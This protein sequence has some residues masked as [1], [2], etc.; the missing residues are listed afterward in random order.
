MMPPPQSV[1]RLRIHASSST[2]RLSHTKLKLNKKIE[3][4][5]N[6]TTTSKMAPNRKSIADFVPTLPNN[7]NLKVQTKFLPLTH[8]AIEEE[9]EHLRRIDQATKSQRSEESS[10]ANNYWNWQADIIDS[11]ENKEREGTTGVFS[12]SSIEANLIKD[13]NGTSSS[14]ETESSSRQVASHDEYW[15]EADQPQIMEE[16]EPAMK[17]PQHVDDDVTSSYYWDWTFDQETESYWQWETAK[18]APHVAD[19][20]SHL[21]T[22]NYWD[23]D[24]QENVRAVLESE[25]AREFLMA[26]NIVRQLLAAAGPLNSC[27]TK[28][29]SDEYWA[30]S[31]HYGDEYWQSTSMATPIAAAGSEGYW[32]EQ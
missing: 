6:K 31:E 26:A 13:A 8:H 18:V 15:T 4:E 11:A 20:A 25:A 5:R 29:S 12:L 21:E 2:S 28:A 14:S 22:D 24:T 3:A 19:P 27:G 10:T 1:G 17:S 7:N 30:F 9:S 16:T 32:D 23:W